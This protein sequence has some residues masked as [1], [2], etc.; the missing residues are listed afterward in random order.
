MD[1]EFITL[2]GTT[3]AILSVLFAYFAVKEIYRTRKHWFDWVVIGLVV[4]VY[5]AAAFGLGV[6]VVGGL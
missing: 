6:M 5:G 2:L 4:L 1:Q 3:M